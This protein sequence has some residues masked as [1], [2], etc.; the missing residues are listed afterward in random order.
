MF[1]VLLRREEEVCWLTPDEVVV[2]VAGDRAVDT[3]QSSFAEEEPKDLLGGG[4]GGW[5]DLNSELQSLE[6]GFAPL[7]L[8]EG[9]VGGET[10]ECCF[11][12]IFLVVGEEPSDEIICS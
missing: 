9:D 3:S 11:C 2:V 1:D 7:L 4:G 5:R 6:F 8:E 12:G 10:E